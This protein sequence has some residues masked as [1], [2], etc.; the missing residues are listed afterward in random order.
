M[1]ECEQMN[2][3][4]E[5]TLVIVKP[6][7]V[8]RGLVGRIIARLE[9]LG[10]AIIGVKSVKPTIEFVRGH[11]STSDAQLEQMGSKTLQTYRNLGLN[12][13]V[14]FG[15]EDSKVIGTHIHEW[16]AEFLSSGPVVAIVVEGAHAVKKV[17]AIAG[18]TMPLDAS[19]GS[20]RGDFASAS[21]ALANVSK[22]A[23]HN[24][25][26]AS[27]NELDKDEP[28]REIAYWFKDSELT[29]YEP[30]AHAALM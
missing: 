10:F 4:I 5:R 3:F 16:N 26:H 30:T 9:D 6:D 14:D 1:K 29:V 23:V 25:I 18:S 7:G 27:D 24:L 28:A 19:P 15:S 21:A 17:R 22:A 11:Y 2:Q 12:P 13:I 8:R 20:I